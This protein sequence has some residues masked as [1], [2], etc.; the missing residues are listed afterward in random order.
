MPLIKVNDTNLYY[1][2][3]G[4]GPALLFLHGWG[5]SGRV[6]GAQQ[7][8]F[9]DR[10]R[11]VTVDW[12]GCGRSECTSV[13]NDLQGAIEDIEALIAALDLDRP[14]LIGSSLGAVF[15]VEMALKSPHLAS[16]VVSVGGPA[17]WP[18]QRMDLHPLLDSLRAERAWFG[19]DWVAH[20]FAPGTPRPLI[21]WTIRQ[22]LE[23]SP[24]IDGHLPVFTTYDPRPRLDDLK[25]P[26][27]Y[28]HGELDPEIP[29][30]VS[31]ECARLTPGATV[32]IIPASGHIPHQE[33]PAAFNEALRQAL[34]DLR[35]AAGA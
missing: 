12:R 13:A 10:W 30:S 21:G 6:W 34:H 28:L 24:F 7:V 8:E 23:A 32:R 31:S 20:W 1:E 22:V 18:S 17:F 9:A 5:T 16:G 19:S 25:V 33:C 29:A 26:V 4:S 14:V 11:V 2:D 27:A 35:G 3:H 15:A